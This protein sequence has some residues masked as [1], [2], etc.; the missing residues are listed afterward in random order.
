MASQIHV[1]RG[2]EYGRPGV[3]MRFGDGK[4]GITT[5]RGEVE[6]PVSS[7]SKRST[8][9]RF[10]AAVHGRTSKFS[11]ALKWVSDKIAASIYH[12]PVAS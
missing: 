2:P 4:A 5:G 7:L 8:F 3:I 6:V 9:S 11:P 10:A 12:M 1:V